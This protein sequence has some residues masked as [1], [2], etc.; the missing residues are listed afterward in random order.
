MSILRCPFKQLQNIK[1]NTIQS[2]QKISVWFPFVSQSYFILLFYYFFFF[3][4]FVYV[5]WFL[6][7]LNLGL[8]VSVLL[9]QMVCILYLLSFFRRFFFWCLVILIWV[10][11]ALGEISYSVH[12]A[13]SE[14][15]A[16]VCVCPGEFNDMES[17]EV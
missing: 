1:F 10:H 5:Y 9:L 8:L 3:Y 14:A 7:I 4:F 17:R 6:L 13:Y 15:Q 2:K 12:G 16:P 11:T